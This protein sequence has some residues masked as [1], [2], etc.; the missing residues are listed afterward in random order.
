MFVEEELTSFRKLTCGAIAL[1][2][3]ATPIAAQ[4]QTTNSAAVP[5]STSWSGTVLSYISSL[6]S[7]QAGGCILPLPNAAPPAAPAVTTPPAPAAPE[8]VVAKNSGGF[9][10]LPILLGLAAIGGGIL[11][12]DDDDEPAS[13]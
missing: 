11:L 1:S 6:C 3:V 2:M 9:P 10:F 8:P 13:A 5:V 4:A 7:Q 12:L